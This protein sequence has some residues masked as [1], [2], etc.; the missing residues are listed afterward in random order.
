VTAPVGIEQRV[1]LLR[2][3]FDEAF[4]LAP[5]A[6]PESFEDLLV[7]RVAGAPY[8]L[9]ARQITGLVASRRI[10]PLPSATPQLLGVAGHRGALVLV[11]SL[12]ALLG[13]RADVKPP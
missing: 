1:R 8:S 11:Y 2:S 12:A 3:A 10:V 4:S 6:T 9:R 5:V 13:H 7:I